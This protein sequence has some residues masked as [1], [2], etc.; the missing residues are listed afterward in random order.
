MVKRVL[1]TGVGGFMGSHAL[2]YILDNTDWEIV[3]IDSFRHRGKTDRLV[4][5]SRFKLIVHDLRVPISEQMRAEIGH[6]D[7]IFNIASESSVDRS[8]ESPRDFIENNT[9]LMLTMLEY[10][11]EARPEKFIHISTDEVYGPAPRDHRHSEGEPHRPSNPYSASKSAQEQFAYAYWRTFNVPIIVTNTMNIIG[12]MQDSEKYLPKVIRSVQTG[13]P[14]TIH[15][16]S[17]GK[18]IGS[19]FYLHADNQISALVFIINNVPVVR[20]GE[21]EMVRLNIVGE[22]EV[23]N[24]EIAEMVAEKVGKPLNYMLVDFH[25]ARPGHDLRYALDGAKMSSLG[26]KAP[27]SLEESI[28]NIVKWYTNNSTWL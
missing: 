8:I 18:T 16:S 13:E 24:L 4:K 19:R 3:G 10:A 21:G 17:D 23:N 11:R 27:L 7:Y 12:E 2:H 26:W 5:N 15:A 6:I 22:R 14:L 28:E 20:Y 25:G 9:A 1:V